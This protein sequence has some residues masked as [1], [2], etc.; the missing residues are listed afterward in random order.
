[1]AKYFLKLLILLTMMSFLFG[2][3]ALG[4]LT[5]MYQEK[6]AAYFMT[7]DGRILVAEHFGGTL[8]NAPDYEWWYGCSPTSTGMI[9]G[10]YDINGYDGKTYS[11]LVPGGTAELSNFGDSSAIANDA[12]ASSG[13]INDYYVAYGNSENDPHPGGTHTFNC[14]ADF[15]GT[16]QDNCDNSDGSTTFYNWT[17][18]NKF[19]AQDAIDQGVTNTSGMYGIGE[20]VDYAGYDYSTLYNQY[21]DTSLSNYFS[22]ND[23]KS[24]INA[25]RPTLI[26]IEGH[27]MFGYGY[28]GSSTVYVHDT[29][30][31]GSHTMTWGGSYSG[32]AHKSVTC[33]TVSNGDSGPPGAATLVS[34]SGTT[35]DTTPTYTWNAVS[36]AT[37]YRLYVHKDGSGNIHDQWYSASSVTSGSTCSVTPSTALDTANHTWWVQT[38]NVNGY[39]PWSTG[40]NFV[41]STGGPP[42]AT[43]LVSP[44][45]TITDA[46]PTY[47][48]NAVSD[49]TYYRLFVYEDGSGTIHDQWYSAS[50]VTSGSTCLVTP[51][52]SLNSGDHTWWVQT[53]NANGYGPWSAGLAFMFSS[54]VPGEATLI[55]PSG[56]ITTTTPTYTWNAVSDATWYR[57]YV[58]EDSS[59]SVHDQWYQ[60]SSITSGTTCSVTPSNH[61][62][63]GDHT[64]WIRT[65]NSYGYGPWSAGM[66]FTVS[67][68]GGGFDEQFNSGN[69]DNW[70]RDSGEWDVTGLDG[71]S[72]YYTEGVADKFA[73]SSYNQDTYSNFDY[74]ARLW[75]YGE[76][77]ANSLFVRTSGKTMTNGLPSNGYAFQYIRDGRYSVWK[78]DNGVETALQSWTTTLDAVNTDDAWNVLRVYANG[79]TFR[80]YINGTLVWKGTDNTFSSGQVGL[81]MY[82]SSIETYNGLYVDWAS[83]NLISSQAQSM[84]SQE[85]EN[86]DPKQR[87]LNKEA[88]Q[89]MSGN[90]NSPQ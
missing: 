17:N 26:H 28:S 18:G 20:Y 66:N 32:S 62:N 41:V 2:T 36:G 64:W 81:G 61:L 63:S 3:T 19:T 57:L 53:W 76:N 13:H 6:G 80:F 86:I 9:M 58:E 87:V 21:V 77:L 42:A 24:E 82:R 67:S 37:W 29:W 1:M 84:D 83:L 39:G 22:W 44:S 16:S 88:N 75:R 59:G 60:A 45:G 71:D 90:I 56:S 55:S 30:D 72:W 25:G 48:W 7:D 85:K 4:A 70:D 8:S 27:T 31:E 52:T 11:N 34:P 46:T 51:S 43:T 73:R 15:M 35:T 12:I 49:A 38:W 79:S 89:L 54:G 14:L 50:S 65:W 47:T 33:L 40:M 5:F 10:Y 68:T 74:Q 69:A 78:F 23:Y